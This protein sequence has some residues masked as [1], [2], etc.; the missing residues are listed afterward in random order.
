LTAEQEAANTERSRVRV[1][2]EHVFG[3]IETAMNGCYVRT[4]EFARA[5]ATIGMNNLAYNLSRFS[6]LMRGVSATSA[7]T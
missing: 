4:I 6:F 1:G 5:Q 2:V 7:S 3:H